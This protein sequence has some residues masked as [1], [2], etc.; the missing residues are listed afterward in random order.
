MNLN[1]IFIAIWPLLGIALSLSLHSH[2]ATFV[3]DIALSVTRRNVSIGGINRYTTLVNDS[4][5]GPVLR[6]TED[7]VTWIRVYNDMTDSNL[8]MHWHGL[9]QAA[10]PFSDGT[11]LASQWPIPP[12]HFFDYELKSANGTAGTYIYHTHVGFST[13]TASGALIVQDPDQPPFDYVDERIIYL[14]EYWNKTDSEVVSGVL[15]SPLQWPG[16]PNGWLINGKSISNYGAVDTSSQ[17]LAVIDVEPGEVYRFRLIAA[18]SLSLALFA[19]ENHSE[20]NIIQADGSYT[21]PQPVELF[22]M[23]SGQRYDALFQAKTCEELLELGKVDF[24]MQL[25]TRERDPLVTNYAILRYMNTCNFTDESQMRLSNIANPQSTPLVLPATDPEYLNY[26]LKPLQDNKFPPASEVTRRII[27]DQ[28]EVIGGFSRWQVN[29]NSWMEHGDILSDYTTPYQ[30]YLVALYENQTE[31]LPDYDAAIVNGGLDPKTRTYPAKVG[32]VIEVVVQNIGA[33]SPANNTLV[34]PGSLDTHP[35]HAHGTHF[36]D[37]GS[38]QG[39]Y[40]PEA[41]EAR[42][43]GTSPIR[44]DTVVL[45]KYSGLVEQDQV[46]SWRAWRMRIDN[47]GVWMVHCHT[48]QHM[49]QGMQTV[50]IHG[51]ADDIMRVGYPDVE[52]YLTYGGDVYGNSTHAPQC[53]HFHELDLDPD[54]VF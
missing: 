25:E 49:I 3:P 12:G 41:A 46:A 50:F 53:L 33:R 2:D 52:G 1:I 54:I 34:P 32:E 26:Q 35:W 13:S 6:L 4:L 20:F 42:L 11:P 7:Q 10:Y 39:A 14:Q 22:Q 27:L 15:A 5:P 51:D 44:R 29:N 48:L 40:D 17:A 18:T 16:Q 8:T 28:Q 45:Y 24:Y 31:Y 23:G 38:G 30:P 19:F 9:A 36:Y 37:I 21:Q 43:S 47:P